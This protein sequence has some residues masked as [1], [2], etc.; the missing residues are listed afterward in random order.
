[1]GHM[2]TTQHRHP[3]IDSFRLHK[4]NMP[5]M[6]DRDT[7]YVIFHVTRS[8]RQSAASCKKIILSAIML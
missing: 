1:M 8:F 2:S 3:N 7:G 4:D 5:D 6:P